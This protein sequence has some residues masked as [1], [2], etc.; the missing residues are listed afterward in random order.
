MRP[1]VISQVIDLFELFVVRKIDNL[2]ANESDIVLVLDQIYLLLVI[3]DEE[4]L[5]HLLFQVILDILSIGFKSYKPTPG[6]LENF[7][8]YDIIVFTRVKLDLLYLFSIARTL[9]II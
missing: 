4:R 5:G 2:C 8:N 6:K 1:I 7:F 9:S 3:H